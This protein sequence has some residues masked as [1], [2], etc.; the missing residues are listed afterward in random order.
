ML[1]PPP[2]LLTEG[3]KT[4]MAKKMIWETKMKTYLKRVDV[5]ESNERAIYSIT[6]GQSSVI[7]Q[8]KIKSLHDFDANNT[9]S[10]CTWLLNE[11]WGIS[12][13]FEATRNIFISLDDTGESFTSNRQGHQALHKHLK[14]F[15]ANV[16][17]LKH[18]G[19]ALGREGSYP[20]A[21]KE[22]MK[23]AAPRGTSNA[24]ILKQTIAAAKNKV[25]AV[26][27]LKQAGMKQYSALWVDLEH[28]FSRGNDQYPAADLTGAFNLLLNFW[29][30]PHMPNIRQGNQTPEWTQTSLTFVQNTAA[31][32]GTTGVLHANIKCFNC[33]KKEHYASNCPEL[34][35]QRSTAASVLNGTIGV[36]EQ[37]NLSTNLHPEFHF[38]P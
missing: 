1:S 13:Q 35:T 23:R 32:A 5:Q 3:Y 25:L 19:A 11:I 26:G 9:S 29:P 17:V 6:W 21:L 34:D 30:T 7:M 22:Q 37:V 10:D 20:D 4:D 24:N 15:P 12:N 8:S 27:S 2:N 38:Q 28:Q 18:Y 31:V 36:H 14:K 33:N 16:Q